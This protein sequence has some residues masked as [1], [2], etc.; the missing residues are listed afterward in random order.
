MQDE[1]YELLSMGN[2]NACP[3]DYLHLSTATIT[4][5]KQKKNIYEYTNITSFTIVIIV[6]NTRW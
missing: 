1:I 4:K 2:N 3:P 6:H 5:E